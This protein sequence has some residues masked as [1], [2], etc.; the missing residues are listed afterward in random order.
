[1]VSML[2]QSNEIFL[3]SYGTKMQLFEMKQH[4]FV[5]PEIL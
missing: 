4:C 5:V 3:V 2:L 1:M